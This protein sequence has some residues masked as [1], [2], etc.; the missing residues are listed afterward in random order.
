MHIQTH[1]VYLGK[2]LKL[3]GTLLVL[4]RLPPMKKI[5]NILISRC[6]KFWSHFLRNYCSRAISH[7]KKKKVAW[8]RGVGRTHTDINR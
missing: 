3:M 4:P 8:E 5:T 2:E 7:S 1:F 6:I